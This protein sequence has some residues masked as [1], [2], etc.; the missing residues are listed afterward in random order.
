MP[1]WAKISGGLI[2]G[3]LTLVFAAIAAV[4]ATGLIKVDA[5]TAISV[6]NRKVAGTP[7]QVARGKDNASLGCVGCHGVKR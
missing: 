5:V 4:A 3:L 2:A 7:E 6:L 1:L